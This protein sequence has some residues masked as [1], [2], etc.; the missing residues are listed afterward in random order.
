MMV[1]WGTS[2]ARQ[3]RHSI[4]PARTRSRSKPAAAH[5]LT[6]GQVDDLIA[7]CQADLPEI[8]EEVGPPDPEA[9][10]TLLPPTGF[11][12]STT[13]R[14]EARRSRVDH[15]A[16][17]LKDET[18]ACYLYGSLSALVGGQIDA[19]AYRAYLDGLLREAGSP[20]DP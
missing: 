4:M 11:D 19:G 8:G 7:A 20:T 2:L 12:L 3:G 9:P 10:R 15:D 5:P 6:A 16:R 1:R 13:I 18:A 14:Q 17:N